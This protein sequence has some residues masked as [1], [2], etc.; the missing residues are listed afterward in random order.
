MNMSFSAPNEATTYIATIKDRCHDLIGN[1]IWTGL[2]MNEI[3]IWL[4][5]FQTPEEEYFAAC[6][7]DSLIFRSA[8]QTKAL[9]VH[10]LNRSLPNLTRFNPTPLGIINNWQQRMQGSSDPGI[11]FVTA[12][13]EA[14]STTKSAYQISRIMRQELGVQINWIIKPTQIEKCIDEG[15]KVFVFIDDL[16]GTG[17]QIIETCEEAGVLN[18]LSKAWIVYAPLV[19][20]QVGIANLKKKYSSIHIVAAEYLD[21]AS[22][23]FENGFIDNINDANKAKEFYDLLLHKRGSQIYDTDNKY[24]FGNLGLAYIFEHGTPDN[25]LHIL[26]DNHNN[27]YPLYKR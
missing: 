1:R 2:Q 16:L 13:K 21:N 8:E 18:H 25:S 14:D 3:N 26:W 20:H 7:L 4:K 11:R 24:G 27:W 17:V 10:L 6:I 5:N 23:V 12:V 22:S 9:A 15:V 19:A